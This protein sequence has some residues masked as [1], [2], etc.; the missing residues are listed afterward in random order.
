[1]VEEEATLEDEPTLE[2]PASA[3]DLYYVRGEETPL[4]RPFLTGDVVSDLEIPGLEDGADLAVLLTHPCGMRTDGVHLADKILAAR[5]RTYPSVPFTK[6]ATSHFKV[7]PLPDLIQSGAH[8][9]AMFNE[10][11]LIRSA[12]L[13]ASKR[14]ACMS[15]Y[16]INLLQQRF[17]W[18]LTRFA[19]P[20]SKLHRVSVQVFREVELQEE[21]TTTAI[22]RGADPLVGQREFHDWLRSN[23]GE[24]KPT[25]QARLADPQQVAAVRREMRALLRDP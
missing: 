7:M 21:W 15:A 4:G 10:A 17:V 5:V 12:R 2:A 22:E 3:D 23:D 1:M 25:R 6:W 13:V 18:H 9:A 14:V 8:A 16:G 24:G 20:T 11:S 19:I